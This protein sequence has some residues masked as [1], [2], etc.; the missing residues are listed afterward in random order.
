MLTPSQFS[1]TVT[2]EKLSPRL[3]STLS[4]NLRS[5][6]SEC[7]QRFPVASRIFLTIALCARE[8]PQAETYVLLD[9][10]HCNCGFQHGEKIVFQSMGRQGCLCLGA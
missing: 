8:A 6:E 3:W 10:C 5:R 4:S 2:A 7:L 1:P 9:V